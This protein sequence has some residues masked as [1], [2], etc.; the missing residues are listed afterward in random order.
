MISD[1]VA[2]IFII[3]LVAL[4]FFCFWL[5]NAGKLVLLQKASAAFYGVFIARSC[6]VTPQ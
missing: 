5:L 1:A 2:L 6:P 4:S 3:I